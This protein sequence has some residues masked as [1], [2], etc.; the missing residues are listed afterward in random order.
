[1]AKGCNEN[2]GLGRE[3][4]PTDLPVDNSEAQQPPSSSIIT[5]KPHE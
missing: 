5:V 1:M 4:G 3:T 2:L